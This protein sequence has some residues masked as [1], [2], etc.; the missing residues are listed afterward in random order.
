ML[1]SFPSYEI[2]RLLGEGGMGEVYLGRHDRLDRLVAIKIL[3]EHLSRDP[4][5]RERF[6]QEA[7][8]QASL[9]HPNIVVLHDFIEEE[10]RL[11]L[12]MEYIEGRGLD[13]VIGKEV[14]PIVA[15]RA[16]QLFLP[17]VD[18]FEY[19]HSKGIIHRDIKPSNILVTTEDRIK[20]TDLGIAK[21]V[22]QKGLTQTGTKLGTLWYMAPEQIKGLDA[23]HLSDIYA[24]GV[25]LFEMVSGRVPFDSTTSSDYEIMDRIVKQDIPD[26]RQFYPDIPE[27]IVHAIIR[28][29]AKEPQERFSSC[30][31][32]KEFIRDGGNVSNP[33]IGT[34][35]HSEDKTIVTNTKAP[36]SHSVLPTP[37]P[38]VS[39]PTPSSTSGKP[40]DQKTPMVSSQIKEI[41]RTRLQG[42]WNTAAGITLV[43]LL[44]IGIPY[45][46]PVVNY[47]SIFVLD[48]QLIL[49]F[50]MVSLGFA[51]IGTEVKVSDIFGGFSRYWGAL[52]LGIMQSLAI[53]YIPVLFG[54]IPFVL[55]SIGSE[56]DNPSLIL[57]GTIG[58]IWMIIILVKRS[59]MYRLVFYIYADQ[60]EKGVM[61]ALKD[62]KA[63][64]NG[65]KARLFKFELSFL[66]WVIVVILTFGIATLWVFPYYNVSLA[67]FYKNLLD[68]LKSENTNSIN[69]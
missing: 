65:H 52:S 35:D 47:I 57:L 5:L 4:M 46:I 9:T 6:H 2:I 33:S 27:Y 39:S 17:L 50:A 58:M 51:S 12:I 14:G 54:L 23:T 61:Q 42:K 53:I 18:A 10:H 19:A 55:L 48:Y 29:T 67:L 40:L 45:F 26:P 21:I 41:A 20:V 15:A 62:S 16:L 69:A 38:V 28:A 3:R 36:K 60:P 11:A 63:I 49:G 44:I 66:G 68:I 30:R 64:T 59:L 43:Y 24:L 7:R 37:P 56:S 8:L 22:G 25:T 34:F 13:K 1:P 31:E 32:F